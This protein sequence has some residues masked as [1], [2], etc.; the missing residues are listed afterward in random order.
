MKCKY[1]LME[2][3]LLYGDGTR[4]C[5]GIAAAHVYDGIVTVLDSVTDITANRQPL[6]ELVKLCNELSL[7]PIHLND[8]VEDFLASL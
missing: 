6:E 1:I 7:E 4:T 8:I 3:T 2:N 5:Y